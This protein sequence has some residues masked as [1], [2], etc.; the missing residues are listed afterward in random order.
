MIDTGSRQRDVL[1]SACS[2]G[3]LEHTPSAGTSEWALA[4]VLSCVCS[5][6]AVPYPYRDQNQQ[7]QGRVALPATITRE[8]GTKAGPTGWSMAQAREQKA[9]ASGWMPPLVAEHLVLWTGP[10]GG[11]REAQ[12]RHGS[13]VAGC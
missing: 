12:Q 3:D 13:A 9:L 2:R 5:M 10:G 6:R 4:T 11:L 1:G 7:S 8:A